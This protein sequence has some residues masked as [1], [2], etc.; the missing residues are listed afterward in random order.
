MSTAVILG[1]RIPQ[2]TATGPR[3]SRIIFREIDMYTDTNGKIVLEYTN[4]SDGVIDEDINVFIDGLIRPYRATGMPVVRT[5]SPLDLNCKEDCFIVFMLSSLVNWQ[6]S[7][8][9]D[10]F[11]TKQVET[12]YSDLYHVHED[13]TR[14]PAGEPVGD[15]CRLLYFRARCGNYGYQDGFNLVIDLDMDPITN[16]QTGDVELRRTK[17]IFDPDIRNPGGSGA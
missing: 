10:C 11:L 15:N 17:I 4:D 14:I 12:R 13:G 7:S 2:D 3:P 6:F 9:G 1:H 16:P 5:G 8:S